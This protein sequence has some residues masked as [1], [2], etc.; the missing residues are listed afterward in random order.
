MQPLS[1]ARHPILLFPWST[2]STTLHLWTCTPTSYCQCWQP[3]KKLFKNKRKPKI[4]ET[5]LNR[6]APPP[7][8]FHLILLTH[9]STRILLYSNFKLCLISFIWAGQPP[10][11]G[12]WDPPSPVKS[13]RFHTGITLCFWGARRSLLLL[14]FIRTIGQNRRVLQSWLRRETPGD[15]WL[16]GTVFIYILSVESW[17]LG[18]QAETNTR[19][20]PD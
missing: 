18:G 1:L 2:W 16:D 3:F 9:Q 11:W 15:C 13:R 19:N 6:N 8:P 10:E 4:Q 7:A 12:C 5:N 20:F 17:F 14:V